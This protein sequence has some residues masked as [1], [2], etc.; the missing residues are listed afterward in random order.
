MYCTCVCLCVQENGLFLY[1]HPTLKSYLG[2]A[3]FC[4]L[5]HKAKTLP[6]SFE[7]GR[8]KWTLLFKKKISQ[9]FFTM[10]MGRGKW[11]RTK[12][13]RQVKFNS[14]EKIEHKSNNILI[15]K[16]CYCYVYPL[17]WW[18]RWIYHIIIIIMIY[19]GTHRNVFLLLL[20]KIAYV[21]RIFLWVIRAF[22]RYPFHF[23]FSS[24]SFLN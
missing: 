9:L 6:S 1:S 14:L 2:W 19:S 16:A 21:C 18:Y 17:S 7:L 8:K 10:S 3:D 23:Q 5:M 11:E 4:P 12:T 15:T 13:E 20:N 24:E 22:Y